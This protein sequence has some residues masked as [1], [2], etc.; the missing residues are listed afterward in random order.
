[1]SCQN[2][3]EQNFVEE[4]QEVIDGNIGNNTSQLDVYEKTLI[5]KYTSDGFEELNVLLRRGGRNEYENYLNAA[6]D[7][8]PNYQGFV[9]RGIDLE[10]SEMDVYKTAYAND[11]IVT[12]PAF[13]STSKRKFL[14]FPFDRTNTL[15]IIS[16]KKGKEIENMSFYGVNKG[17]NQNENEVLFKSKTAFSVLNIRQDGLRV[18]IELEEI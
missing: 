1:M 14:S 16:S 3:V 6:L 11:S 4:L 2:F 9:Y 15:F 8:L 7:K 17:E 18:V 10:L 13:T 5:Y 12:E